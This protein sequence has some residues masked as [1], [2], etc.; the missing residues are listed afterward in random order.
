MLS[1]HGLRGV[2]FSAEEKVDIWAWGCVFIEMAVGQHPWART[3]PTPKYPKGVRPS[4]SSPAGV[5]PIRRHCSKFALDS[6][7]GRLGS[8]TH[9]AGGWLRMDVENDGAREDHE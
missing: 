6:V 9:L 8:L 1:V 4:F 7:R 3:A 2:S 5:P